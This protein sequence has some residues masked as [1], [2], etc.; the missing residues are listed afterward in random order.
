MAGAR[1]TASQMTAEEV[2]SVRAWQRQFG[3]AIVRGEFVPDEYEIV[4][5]GFGDPDSDYGSANPWPIHW[6]RSQR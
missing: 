5:D 1:A 3:Y 2:R 4:G 6:P